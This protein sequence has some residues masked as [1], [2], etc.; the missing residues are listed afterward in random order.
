MQKLQQPFLYLALGIT[1]A[2]HSTEEYLTRLYDW[3]PIVSGHIRNTT[4]LFPVI[5]MSVQ[6]FVVL[7]IALITFLLSISPFVFLNK[8]WASKIATVVALTEILNGTAHI[9]AS[10]Y[11]GGYFT[12]SVS[13]IGLLAVAILLTKSLRNEQPNSG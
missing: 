8:L 3:F 12:G 6:T 13:A 2:A 9:S 4:R 5:R 10:I 7:N 11:V 1:Q